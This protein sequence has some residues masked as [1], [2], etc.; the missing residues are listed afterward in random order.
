MVKT[1]TRAPGQLPSGMEE[2]QVAAWVHSSW[3][4]VLGSGPRMRELPPSQKEKKKKKAVYLWKRGRG[5]SSSDHRC[6]CGLQYSWH[7]IKTRQMLV[8]N[9]LTLWEAS[10]LL[11]PQQCWLFHVVSCWGLEEESNQKSQLSVRQTL[12]L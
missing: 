11:G 3:V 5:R 8:P 6:T 7:V 12:N 10:W 2:A 4:T 1:G 9:T